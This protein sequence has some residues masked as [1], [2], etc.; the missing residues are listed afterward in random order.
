V[1]NG[2]TLGEQSGFPSLDQQFYRDA[3]LFV[4][5]CHR[6]VMLDGQEI[7]LTRMQHQLL[8]LL[9]EHAGEIVSRPT[10]ALWVWG[11]AWAALTHAG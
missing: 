7:T 9:V 5:L 10:L 2:V 11:C 1:K 6:V 4:H 8:A 3:H